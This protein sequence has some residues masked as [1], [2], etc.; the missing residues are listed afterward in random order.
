MWL[1]GSFEFTFE[2]EDV[3]GHRVVVGSATMLRRQLADLNAATWRASET[4][5]A[6]WGNTPPRF[7]ATLELRSRYAFAVFSDLARRAVDH[8]LPMKLDY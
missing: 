7:E 2:G 3:D 5:V 1:P 6:G 4:T 8:R